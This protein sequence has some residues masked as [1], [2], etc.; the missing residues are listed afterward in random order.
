MTVYQA[1]MLMFVFST[2]IITV[3]NFKQKK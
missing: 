2:L 3:L 1:L